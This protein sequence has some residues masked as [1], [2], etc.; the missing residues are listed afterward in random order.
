MIAHLHRLRDLR[1]EHPAWRQEW[2]DLILDI[3]LLVL[4]HALF[5]FLKGSDAIL[6]TTTMLWSLLKT[7]IGADDLA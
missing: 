6:S 3:L 5:K 7:R 1:V 4:H 2:A